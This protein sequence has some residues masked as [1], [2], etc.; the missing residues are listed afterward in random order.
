[1]QTNGSAYTVP[2][3][4]TVGAPNGA[5][6]G[7]RCS[8]ITFFWVSTASTSTPDDNKVSVVVSGVNG[9]SYTVSSNYQVHTPSS[10]ATAT[11]GTAGIDAAVTKVGLVFPPAGVVG[12]GINF[13]GRV[14]TSAGFASGE[15]TFLQ[16][17]D[18]VRQYWDLGW[19]PFHWSMNG[20]R[21][22]DQNPY[23]APPEDPFNSGSGWIADGAPHITRDSP[24]KGLA[25]TNQDLLND[26][27]H[28]F[29][30]FRPP[31][32][33]SEWVPLRV[34]DWAVDIVAKKTNN[35]WAVFGTPHQSMTPA[36]GVFNSQATEPI[37]NQSAANG[38][39][40]PGLA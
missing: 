36:N 11:M 8:E 21:T 27:F 10:T 24:A 22:L 13:Q 20:L 17:V 5:S 34:L 4:D 9:N 23:P 16:T 38:S 26:A 19:N 6:T 33:G 37:W 25:N 35:V 7:Y 15:W 12:G 32:T 18:T 14:T 2:V 29:L 30:M 28:T 39:W 31:G 1:V 3:T 40:L